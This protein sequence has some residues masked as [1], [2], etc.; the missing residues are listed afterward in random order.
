MTAVA[1]ALA[2]TSSPSRNGKNASEAHT[3]PVV[4]SPSSRARMTAMRA[5]STRFICPAPTPT[6]WSAVASTIALD[7]ACLATRQAKRSAA[8]LRLGGRRAA[9][10]R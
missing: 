9:R 3:E 6:T 7:L 1:P 2:T 4:S 8:Q 5:E 10:P